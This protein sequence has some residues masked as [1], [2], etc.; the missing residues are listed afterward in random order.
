MQKV[1]YSLSLKHLSLNANKTTQQR[2]V[3]LNAAKHAG[4]LTLLHIDTHK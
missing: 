3:A 4:T 2:N 1:M